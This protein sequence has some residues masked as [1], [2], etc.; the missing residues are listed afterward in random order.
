LMSILATTT[1]GKKR[2]RLKSFLDR[3]KTYARINSSRYVL[4]GKNGEKLYIDKSFDV[5]D[6]LFRQ[7]ERDLEGSWKV[8]DF[9][10]DREERVRQEMHDFMDKFEEGGFDP[11][12]DTSSRLE[13]QKIFNTAREMGFNPLDM[14][15]QQ[16][17]E[18]EKRVRFT[19]KMNLAAPKPVLLPS[20]K[21]RGTLN[22]SEEAVSYR[23]SRMLRMCAACGKQGHTEQ[24][25]WGSP[26]EKRLVV[27]KQVCHDGSNCSRLAVFNTKT[28]TSMEDYQHA[29]HHVVTFYHPETSGGQTVPSNVKTESKS[30]SGPYLKHRNG[31]VIDVIH[32]V[33]GE[34]LQSAFRVGCE[35]YTTWHKTFE[36]GHPVKLRMLIPGI[37][38]R[39]FVPGETKVLDKNST[40]STI[41]VSQFVQR[42]DEDV[43]VA[44][45]NVSS[46]IIPGFVLGRFNPERTYELAYRLVDGDKLR[47]CTYLCVGAQR[48]T[49]PH[50]RWGS[51][52]SYRT[53]SKAGVS[54]S[55]MY[56][57]D[58]GVV[59]GMHVGEFGSLLSL[60]QCAIYLAND[61]HDELAA[62]EKRQTFAG[63]FEVNLQAVSPSECSLLPAHLGT[64]DSHPVRHGNI[65]RCPEFQRYL[66]ETKTGWPDDDWIMTDPDA[67]TLYQDVAKYGQLLPDL[68]REAMTALKK[69]L[70]YVNSMLEP[71]LCNSGW[72]THEQ[73]ISKM[74]KDATN[75]YNL[76]T[77]AKD[78]AEWIV[79]YG[80]QCEQLWLDFLSGKA[81]LSYVGTAFGKKEIRASEKVKA[82]KIRSIVTLNR[83][84]LYLQMRVF[85]TFSDKFH[86]I[87]MQTWSALGM[88][89]FYG[90]W[91]RL[92]QKHD[93]PSK[94]YD[95]KQCDSRQR[96]EISY[97][98]H[99]FRFSCLPPELQTEN[100]KRALTRLWWAR[101]KIPIIV[102]RHVYLKE[103][104]TLTGE[105]ITADV[106]TYGAMTGFAFSIF[107]ADPA[108]TFHDMEDVDITCYGDDSL[109]SMADVLW[110]KFG[111]NVFENGFARLGMYLEAEHQ[112]PGPIDKL[113]FL[114]MYG[115]R[116]KCGV[117]PKPREGKILAAARWIK[118]DCSGL[119]VLTTK[120]NA[121]YILLY[122]TPSVK[123]VLNLKSWAASQGDFPWISSSDVEH[124]YQGTESSVS[125]DNPAAI[126]ASM[127]LFDSTCG[128]PGEGQD[129]EEKRAPVDHRY[130]GPPE[131]SFLKASDIHRYNRDRWNHRTVVFVFHRRV[132]L[133][134]LKRHGV[135]LTCGC[136]TDC[137][138]S[139]A[140]HHTAACL[141]C[142]LIPCHAHSDDDIASRVLQLLIE[143]DCD[144]NWEK[145]P[146]QHIEA[147]VDTSPLVA[148]ENSCVFYRHPHK[149]WMV[150]VRQFISDMFDHTLGYEGEGQPRR[151][152]S[153]KKPNIMSNYNPK[154]TRV[155]GSACAANPFPNCA[156]TCQCSNCYTDRLE[157]EVER[158]ERMTFDERKTKSREKQE[159]EDFDIFIAAWMTFQEHSRK[160]KNH[161]CTHIRQ[162]ATASSKCNCRQTFKKREFDSTLGYP[163]EG[164][165]GSRPRKDGLVQK[166][167][168]R[169]WWDPV[170]LVGHYIVGA[171]QDPDIPSD[172]RFM[173]GL[174]FGLYAHDAADYVWDKA[175]KP[176]SS[177]VYKVV[178]GQPEKGEK[179]DSTLG[180]PG[181]GPPKKNKVKAILSKRVRAAVKAS[182]KK[183]SNRKINKAVTSAIKGQKNKMRTKNLSAVPHS[184]IQSDTLIPASRIPGARHQFASTKSMSHVI[185][186][187]YIAQIVASAGYD[188]V[189]DANGIKVK[190]L[191]INPYSL[192]TIGKLVKQ[193][194]SRMRMY[195]NMYEKFRLRVTFR[196]IRSAPFTVRGDLVWFFDKDA[197]DSEDWAFGDQRILQIAKN[198][199]QNRI[200]PAATSTNQ[201]ISF[202]TP[203]LWTRQK[204]SNGA[205]TDIRKVS[206]GRF[207]FLNAESGAIDSSNGLGKLEASYAVEF[208]FPTL[209]ED[210]WDYQQTTATGAV[211]AGTAITISSSSSA[212]VVL[213]SPNVRFQR[214]SLGITKTYYAVDDHDNS[215][216][217]TSNGG[218]TLGEDHLVPCHQFVRVAVQMTGTLSDTV[219]APAMYASLYDQ[220]GLNIV[221][222]SSS[223]SELSDAVPMITYLSTDAK[224]ISSV[225]VFD[226]HIEPLEGP[227]VLDVAMVWTTARDSAGFVTSLTTSKGTYS[228]LNWVSV[229]K[230]PREEKSF[231]PDLWQEDA[232]IVDVKSA[233]LAQREPSVLAKQRALISAYLQKLQRAEKRVSA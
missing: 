147:V 21:Q 137:H 216:S 190:Y 41:A 108:F 88:C 226:V 196:F 74:N 212:T 163:G 167:N 127:Q 64:V 200:F 51:I 220:N 229:Q 225:A 140:K 6:Y 142:E 47:D 156:S 44:R 31:Y 29:A 198:H 206:A 146:G 23:A 214:T 10:E 36:Y 152:K 199:P 80:N 209:G 215:T 75:G 69:G 166:F 123:H 185:G 112:E 86:E 54:G 115:E 223:T 11:R 187:E 61:I 176:L 22:W 7:R 128:Y 30:F 56:D 92:F 180:Y 144:R 78:C 133:A 17:Y 138:R 204:R 189:L 68:D 76:N 103:H 224:T 93:K 202:N 104:G 71:H 162:A 16:K 218:M 217:L 197:S 141:G 154:T 82:R 159:Q 67:S 221:T 211:S 119:D 117:M 87:P 14:T 232:D 13:G 113:A 9:G 84:M 53:Q 15:N 25:C 132:S 192:G 134:L 111:S 121:L 222:T 171:D 34:R 45:C 20:R 33:T 210:N 150:E 233:E 193:L 168:Q 95:Q 73:V 164:H 46:D 107:W 49:S 106:N 38:A 149:M 55:P 97:A 182:G 98:F 126:A 35:I 90:W 158:L 174:P 81:R 24:H 157:R 160:F 195:C 1:E 122:N 40:H 72:A 109:A 110:K 184:Q 139:T 191:D 83:D 130:V 124:L 66:D 143:Y 183:T 208:G 32:A 100:V 230:A 58:S 120:I 227:Y 169:P 114:S 70:S 99:M 48:D 181:E 79:K 131:N 228:P 105:Y 50:P 42:G 19:D 116:T 165:F 26:P 213:T 28:S 129:R 5:D 96:N 102:N 63:D 148:K 205:A 77:T 178:A 52:L 62:Y 89:P 2:M 65:K 60:R 57:V 3:V 135:F 155:Y 12:H 39:E 145:V 4:E 172:E 177:L 136:V 194:D 94:G 125:M 175:I 18:V 186:S 173:A 8:K 161:G 85:L 151:L 27:H 37:D 207:Y 179:F 118:G 170:H 91:N 201:E 43:M 188:T 59:V 101:A 203:W 153:L 231:D 219:S